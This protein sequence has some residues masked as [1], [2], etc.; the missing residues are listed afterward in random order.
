ML[1]DENGGV[2]LNFVASGES[3][4][5]MLLDYTASGQGEMQVIANKTAIQSVAFSEATKSTFICIHPKTGTNQVELALRTGNASDASPQ[6]LLQQL[7][8]VHPNHLDIGIEADQSQLG[9]GWSNSLVMQGSTIRWVDLPSTL[10]MAVCD[11]P[12]SAANLNFRAYNATSSS[13]SV[14]LHLNDLSLGTLVLSQ[15][16]DEYSLRLSNKDLVTD[17]MN[18]IMISCG[19][20]EASTC[21]LKEQVGF[22]WLNITS[23]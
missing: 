10:S 12:S 16:W 1:L 13:L 23:K 7:T 8:F 19:E 5:G 18:T 22:D 11:L 2:Q 17:G 3:L 21:V 15:G 20:G 14:E 9:Q 4:V 6:V